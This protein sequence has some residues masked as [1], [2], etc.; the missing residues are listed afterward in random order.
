MGGNAFDGRY[1]GCGDSSTHGTPSRSAAIPP[2]AVSTSEITSS[3]SMAPS[4]GRISV[5]MCA[6]R[7]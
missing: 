4:S 6:A 2:P 1:N 3:G 7:S 5:E